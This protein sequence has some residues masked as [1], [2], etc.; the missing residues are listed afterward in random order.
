MPFM[1]TSVKRRN[2]KKQGDRKNDVS[3][4]LRWHWTGFLDHFAVLSFLIRSE[5]SD[6]A[7]LAIALQQEAIAA[8]QGPFA[9]GDC[10]AHRA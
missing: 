2:S 10:V 6:F 5:S 9:R 3:I 4:N 8:R 7:D 1:P